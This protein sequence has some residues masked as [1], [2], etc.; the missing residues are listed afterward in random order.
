MMSSMGAIL[1][2]IPGDV[3]RLRHAHDVAVRHPRD[4]ILWA[5]R[6]IAFR[7]IV[8]LCESY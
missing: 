4:M 3:S 5:W 8:I 7:L 1:H 6:S 2:W